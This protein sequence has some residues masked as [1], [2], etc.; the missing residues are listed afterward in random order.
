MDLLTSKKIASSLI[1][2]EKNFFKIGRKGYQKK[3]N[4][5]LISK[6]L[7][8][9]LDLLTSKKIAS[10]LIRVEKNFFKIGRKGYQKKQNFVLISKKR[11]EVPKDF[12]SEKR[13][14]A[15]KSV[16]L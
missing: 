3:Q 7:L 15:K 11:Q 4:F 14:F 6:L 9:L 12:F 5:V 2:V 10:S 13:F 1:R 16:F 8:I